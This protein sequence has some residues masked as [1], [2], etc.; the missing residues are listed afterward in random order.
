MFGL[1]L[2]IPWKLC[3]ILN[4][5]YGDI[6]E[7]ASGRFFTQCIALNIFIFFMATSFIVY[8]HL[9]FREFLADIMV[10]YINLL[11]YLL[12]CCFLYFFYK[13]TGMF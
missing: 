3:G 2:N 6:K 11:T 13:Q 4:I 9:R 8:Q 10:G 7:N 1:L 12:N 5:F